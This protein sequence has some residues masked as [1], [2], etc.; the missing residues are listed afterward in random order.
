[1][2]TFR[3]NRAYKQPTVPPPELVRVLDQPVRGTQAL[4]GGGEGLW[5]RAPVV[6]FG[7]QGDTTQPSAHGA[8]ALLGAST[9]NNQVNV[10]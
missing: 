2:A 7:L 4:E 6:N 9:C 3:E 5:S 10:R 8:S 1:V